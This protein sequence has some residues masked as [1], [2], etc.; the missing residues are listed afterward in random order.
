M[1]SY[2]FLMDPYGDIVPCNG[3]TKKMSMGNLIEK[4]FDDTWYSDQANA[5]RAAVKTCNKSCW[6]IG[7]ASPSM[8]QRIW[9]PSAWVVKHKIKGY[10][11]KEEKFITE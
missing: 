6:M 9:V 7:S 10:K 2:A 1:G 11:L 4:S 5:V 8:H 3:M